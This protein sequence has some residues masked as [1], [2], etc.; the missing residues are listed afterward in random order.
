MKKIPLILLMSLGLGATAFAQPTG[1]VTMSTDP[2]KAAA[3]ERHAAELK[4]RP[5]PEVQ[6]KPAAKTSTKHKHKTK[7]HAKQPNTSAKPAPKPVAAN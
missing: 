4:A 1:G 6:A 2:A 7:A 3:V 5:A